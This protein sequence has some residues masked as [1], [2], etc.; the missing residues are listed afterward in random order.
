MEIIQWQ[1]K[2]IIYISNIE[3]KTF[4]LKGFK[5][6]TSKYLHRNDTDNNITIK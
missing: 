6:L 3:L 1:R 4:T 5:A 2:P